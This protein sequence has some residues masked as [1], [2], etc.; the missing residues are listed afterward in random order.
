MSDES[1]KRKSLNPKIILERIKD[2]DGNEIKPK[3]SKHMKKIY[4]AALNERKRSL[5]SSS[6]RKLSMI[7]KIQIGIIENEDT[8]KDLPLEIKQTETRGRGIFAKKMIRKDSFIVEYIGETITKQEGKIRHQQLAAIDSD[9][10]FLF[11]FGKICI[12]ATEETGRYGRLMNHALKN[13]NIKPVSVKIDGKTKIGFVS[14][15]DIM[16]GEELRWDYGDPEGH[17][18]EWY[19]K[20]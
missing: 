20:D 5:R 3:V 17:K 2:K 13:K 12:D 1:P 7:D 10:N 9:A 4:S 18:L 11:F 14:L 8:D 6:S 19:T 15:R 16:I